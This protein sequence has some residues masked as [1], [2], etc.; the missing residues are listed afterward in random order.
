MDSLVRWMLRVTALVAATNS[1]Q[2]HAMADP[3]ISPQ[4]AFNIIRQSWIGTWSCTKSMTNTK[5][6]QW[7]E[8]VSAFG[9]RWIRFTGVYPAE[10]T[11]PASAYESVLGYDSERHQWVTVTFLADGSYGID[12][13]TSGKNAMTVTWVNAYPI[14]SRVPATQ[15][16]T[17]H[18]FTVD[19]TYKEAGKL[20]S[21]HW[22]CAKH[23]RP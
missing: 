7:T 15:V 23:Y 16:M 2:A 11:M 20:I 17:K 8:T 19:G 12:R 4:A 18:R 6:V 9:N 3:T 13:G 5:T 22:N 1:T 21:F 14:E 10:K